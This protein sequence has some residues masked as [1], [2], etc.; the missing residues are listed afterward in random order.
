MRG[1]ARGL[2]GQPPLDPLPPAPPSSA[3]TLGQPAGKAGPPHALS[4]GHPHLPTAAVVPEPPAAG[5]QRWAA[6]GGSLPR[7]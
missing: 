3:P 7:D 2:Q 4:A 1:G 6:A 5:D